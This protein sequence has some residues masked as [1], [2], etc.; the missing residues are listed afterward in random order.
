MVLRLFTVLI[1]KVSS[2]SFFF[3]KFKIRSK[4]FLSL[5]DTVSFK[6]MILKKKQL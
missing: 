4:I 3:M 2:F 1:E 5:R 6:F